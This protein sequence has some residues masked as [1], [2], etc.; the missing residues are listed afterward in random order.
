MRYI[1]NADARTQ[2]NVEAVK[3]ASKTVLVRTADNLIDAEAA[4]TAALRDELRR[5]QSSARHQAPVIVA[6]EVRA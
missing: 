5:M 2:N 1:I 6:R 4:Q 3:G